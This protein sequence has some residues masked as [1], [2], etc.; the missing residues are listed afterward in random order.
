MTLIFQVTTGPGTDEAP[1]RPAQYDALRAAMA[2]WLDTGRA[3]PTWYDDHGEELEGAD[4]HNAA[5]E[6][7]P[8]E[9]PYDAG[10]ELRTAP[11]EA[12]RTIDETLEL[13]QVSSACD[14][15]LRREI[16]RAYAAMR[17][18]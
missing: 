4:A 3:E 10:T 8:T 2:R 17:K 13:D 14:V 9:L 6:V 15:D 1:S 12:W 16:G 18:V 11:T 7:T 5:I